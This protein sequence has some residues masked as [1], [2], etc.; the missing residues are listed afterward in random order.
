M[1]NYN[2]VEY[3]ARLT[4]GVEADGRDADSKMKVFP[5]HWVVPTSPGSAPTINLCKVPKGFKPRFVHYA[6]EALSVSAGVNL[7]VRIG[8]A[9]DGT[10][11]AND[12]RLMPDIDSDLAQNSAFVGLALAGANFEYLA[13]TII[14]ATVNSGK[15]PVAGKT[16]FGYIAGTREG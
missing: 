9:G 6:C 7:L 11:S 3:A 12:A 10:N 5:F 16:I 15:T 4:L 1:S 14:V 2:S 8:D 13:D